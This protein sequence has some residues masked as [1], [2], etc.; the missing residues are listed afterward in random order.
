MWACPDDLLDVYAELRPPVAASHVYNN[1]DLRSL[2]LTLTHS[3]TLFLSHTLSLTLTHTQ[4]LTH[5]STHTLLT[6]SIVHSN[7]FCPMMLT[8]SLTLSYYPAVSLTHSL[9]HL[10]TCTSFHNHVT[11]SSSTPLSHCHSYIIHSFHGI[12]HSLTQLP[13]HSFITYSLMPCTVSQISALNHST[14]KCKIL[15]M[16]LWRNGASLTVSSSRRGRSEKAIVEELLV[17]SI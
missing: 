1:D 4:A 9:T 6:H 5:S 10:Q 2:T 13:T 3:H 16:N 12:I 14:I 7:H 15:L 17:P 8:P 11:T